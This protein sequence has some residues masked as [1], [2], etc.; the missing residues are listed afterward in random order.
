MTVKS[1]AQTGAAIVA[2][3]DT[4][5]RAAVARLRKAIE[6]FVETGTPP[7]PA[8]RQDG[9]FAYPEIRLHYRGDEALSPPL[10]SFGRL[11]EAGDY[12]TSVTKPALFADYLAEQIDILIADYGV[13]VIARPG[14]QEIPFPYVLD[15]NDDLADVRAKDLSRW[16]PTMRARSARRRR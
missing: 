13:E 12:L 4:M 5:F 8:M 3:L 9:S 7:D 2:E 16:F 6:V 11:T 1:K 15:A 14:R 10:R